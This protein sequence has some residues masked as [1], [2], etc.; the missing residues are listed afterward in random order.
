MMENESGVNNYQILF[1][2]IICS[3]SVVCLQVKMPPRRDPEVTMQNNMARMAEAVT[4]L[5]RLMTQQ[6]NASAAQAEAQTQGAAAKEE[7]KALRQQREE[8]QAAAKG[9]NDFR[10]HEP[11]RFVGTAGPEKAEIWV[12][13]LENIFAVLQ[14]PVESEFGYASS[15]LVGEAE[16]WWRGARLMLE[17]NQEEVNWR[18]F[19]RVFLEKYFPV[20]AQEAKE[21][22]FLTLKQ[23]TM[24][25]AEYASKLES[26]AKHFRFFKDQVDEA[27]MCA[28]FLAGLKYEIERGVRSL[29]IRRFQELVARSIV[30]EEMENAR[31]TLKGSGGPIR[32][33][34]EGRKFT[35]R[36]KDHR[37]KPYQQFQRKGKAQGPGARP[38]N[39]S[40]QGEVVCFKCAQPGHYASECRGEKVCYQCKRPGHLANDCG[41]AGAKTAGNAASEPKPKAQARVY[42]VQGQGIVEPEGLIQ[43]T[44]EIA[45]IEDKK[46]FD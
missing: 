20:S 1:T 19:K 14:P 26:L 39:P 33:H 9:L 11:P 12:Q 3:M 22:Q 38:G 15:L 13:E 46:E 24:S 4:G 23:G 8:A 30:V 6:A 43:R 2:R 40:N 5:T 41:S 45:G 31:G 18:S 10:R 27:Y 17:A 44:G 29:G 42:A 35:N 25:V 34:D 36:R 7:R 21:T 16:Y 28:R 32:N 37:K